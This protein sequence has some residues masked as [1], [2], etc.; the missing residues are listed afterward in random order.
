VHEEVVACAIL[1]GPEYNTSNGIVY[2]LLQSLMINGPASAWISSYEHFIDGRT[3][4]KALVNYYEGDSMKT[5]SKQ[6]CY[7]AIAEATYKGNL[8]N[9][10]FMSYVT[11]SSAG[12]PRS[13][14]TR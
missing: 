2:D 1:Q 9:F 11:I 8:C 3:A 13:Y 10:D 7:D 5:H 6:E 12:L 14:Q 4:W